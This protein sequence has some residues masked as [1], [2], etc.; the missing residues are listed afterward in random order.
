[1]VYRFMTNVLVC[2]EHACGMGGIKVELI[3]QSIILL[4]SYSTAYGMQ[5]FSLLCAFVYLSLRDT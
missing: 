4:K 1:M 2:P 3:N 5:P